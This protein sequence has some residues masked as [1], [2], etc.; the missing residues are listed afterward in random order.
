MK[1]SMV[2]ILEK[3][4]VVLVRV[5]QEILRPVKCQNTRKVWRLFLMIVDDFGKKKMSLA[6]VV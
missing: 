1:D 5:V 4:I 6:V 3:L 2:G